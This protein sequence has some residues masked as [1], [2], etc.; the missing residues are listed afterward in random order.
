M[1]CTRLGINSG[2]FLHRIRV[3]PRGILLGCGYPDRCKPCPR[4]KSRRSCPNRFP[5]EG[6]GSRSIRPRR[7]PSARS[8][9]FASI[10]GPR[11][12]PT[13]GDSESSECRRDQMVPGTE[14]I[15]QYQLQVLALFSA[16]EGERLS[17]AAR[18]RYMRIL[19]DQPSARKFGPCKHRT[20]SHTY[21]GPD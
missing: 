2:P 13:F 18:F 21:E 19:G 1:P 10:D 7:R 16:W 12:G 6:E 14:W 3:L 11:I 15:I 5:Q 17:H 8:R 9:P 4:V 20:L